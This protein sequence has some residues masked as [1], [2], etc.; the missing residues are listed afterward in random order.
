MWPSFL[1]SSLPYAFVSS[2]PE[3]PCSH[4]TQAPLVLVK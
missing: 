4:I 1:S 2:R 3:Y